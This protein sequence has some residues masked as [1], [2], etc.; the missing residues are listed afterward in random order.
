MSTTILGETIDIHAGGQDL[1]F[2]HHENEIAQSEAKTGQRYVNYWMHNGYINID[3]QKM[4]KSLNNFFTA[5]EILDE[6]DPEVV[7]FFILQAHYRS[8]INFSREL[9]NAAKNGLERLYNV[10]NNLQFKIENALTKEL[11]PDEEAM[12]ETL[13]TY[14]HRFIDVMDD[15]FNTADGIAVIFEM[16]REINTHMQDEHSAEFIEGMQD[17]FLTL[18]N[19]LGILV[20]EEEALAADIEALIAE[21]Q[22]A[23][24]NKDFKRADEIRDELSA[25]GIILEDT[26]QGVKWHRKG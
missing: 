19:V 22:S 16:A 8:P 10:R 25:K 18:T 1:I 17:Q 4:S 3:N 14:K 12:L 23:R 24:K 7:R 21:R 11:T 6:F 20:K 9:M 26:P 15:D 5:R 2:P 13:N